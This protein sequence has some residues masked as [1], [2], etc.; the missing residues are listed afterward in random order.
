M[1]ETEKTKGPRKFVIIQI[2]KFEDY[3][4][5]LES[6]KFENNLSQLEKNKLDLSSLKY[7]HKK[8]IKNKNTILKS[9]QEIRSERHNVFTEEVN[10]IALSAKN[11]KRMQ[12]SIFSIKLKEEIKHNNLI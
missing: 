12:Q 11:D 8:F 5:G 9:Q 1:K 2:P 4:H 3:K 7:D 10:K 6:S